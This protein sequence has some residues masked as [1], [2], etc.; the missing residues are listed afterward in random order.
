MT[1][2]TSNS[3]FL[4]RSFDSPDARSRMSTGTSST[5]RP[6]QIEPED[7]LHLGGAARVRLSEDRERLRVRRVETAR[8]VVKRTSERDLH[9]AAQQP[10]A[11]L[12]NALGRVAIG[13]VAF[14]ADEARADGD[15]AVPGAHELEQAPQ[16]GR[17]VLPVGVDAAAIGV[18]LL[19]S[20]RVAGRDAG[21]RPRLRPNESTSA[22]WSAATA[23]VRSVEPSSTT[24]TC[25]SGSSACNSSRTSGRLSSSF[26]AGMK[27]I[28]SRASVLT[29]D[30]SRS[31]QPGAA[32][33]RS[34]SARL[35][36]RTR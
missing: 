33:T 16:L 2:I 21:P 19:C 11:E 36:V 29:G 6:F 32:A 10:G 31:S 25:A 18:A 1:V 23:A 27:T 26:H 34:Q 30:R 17:R 28:V 14:A 8:S 3:A 15:V 12:A 7:R 35:I 13:L 20:V 22:P 4:P 5:R 24:S 9:P